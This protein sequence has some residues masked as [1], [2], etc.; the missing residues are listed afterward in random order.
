MRSFGK[1]AIVVLVVVLPFSLYSGGALGTHEPANKVSAAGSTV[2]VVGPGENV[3]LL[4]DRI[5]T[6]KP[7]DLI[8]SVT[9]ECAI[10]TELTTIG[11]DLANAMGQVKIWVE[12]DGQ[13]VKVSSDDTD[14]PGKVVFCNRIE[15]RET[16]LFDDE[17]A[18]IRTFQST[19]QANGFNWMA[20]DVGSAI[21]TITVKA[22]LVT[23]ATSNASALA[24]VGKRTLII[25]PTKAANDEAVTGLG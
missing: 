6:S 14:E 9:A 18:T 2:E 24:A 17:D 19:R 21:H 4:S 3:T 15:E 22:E 7:T 12:I 10:T 5:R 23:D 13:P 16:T 20:L 25:E 8:L 1:I 11:N